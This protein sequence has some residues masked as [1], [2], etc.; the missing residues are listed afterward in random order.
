[1]R[2]LGRVAAMAV[3]GA[4][5]LIAVTLAVLA[6]DPMTPAEHE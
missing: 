5:L 6:G 3:A 2:S 1:M 4:C